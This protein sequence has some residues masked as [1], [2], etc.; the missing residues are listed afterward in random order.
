LQNGT[1]WLLDTADKLQRFRL[2]PAGSLQ[3]NGRVSLV[4]FAASK[5]FQNHSVQAAAS[6]VDCVDGGSCNVF[7]STTVNFTGGGDFTP[8]TFDF[9]SQS[10]TLAPSHNLE[11]WVI[12]TSGRDMWIAYDTIGYESSLTIAS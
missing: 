6:L 1:L 3:L 12:V 11:L 2:D 10:R 8:Q 4:L 9:G 5:D 7:A